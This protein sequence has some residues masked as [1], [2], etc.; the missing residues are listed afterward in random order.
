VGRDPEDLRRE[1][2]AAHPL[3]RLGTAEEVAELVCFLVSDRAG[4]ITDSDIPIDGGIRSG[5]YA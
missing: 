5:L 3:D 1:W 2:A 4:F